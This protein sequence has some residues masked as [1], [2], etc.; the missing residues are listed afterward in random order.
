[1]RKY[2]LSRAQIKNLAPG[3]VGLMSG[4]HI[5]TIKEST[6]Q[7]GEGLVLQ[8]YLLGLPHSCNTGPG[9]QIVL[10]WISF[11]PLGFGNAVPISL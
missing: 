5:V 4:S 10:V 11:C 1:M 6:R 9:L 7:R 3:L 8:V 2:L